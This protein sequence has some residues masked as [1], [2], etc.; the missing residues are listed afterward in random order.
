MSSILILSP[1]RSCKGV[2]LGNHPLQ[3]QLVTEPESI[4]AIAKA[5][6]GIWTGTNKWKFSF[7]ADTAG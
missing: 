3:R 5:L 4:T 6:Q 2:F 7:Q 1:L